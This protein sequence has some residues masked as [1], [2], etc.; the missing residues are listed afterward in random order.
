MDW[1]SQAKF[2]QV[3]PLSQRNSIL[4]LKLPVQLQL[5]VLGALQGGRTIPFRLS[6]SS[7]YSKIASE[8][9]HPEAFS[10]LSLFL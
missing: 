8:P 4:S 3:G 10:V 6:G 5:E 7:E 9:E 2:Q 1:S